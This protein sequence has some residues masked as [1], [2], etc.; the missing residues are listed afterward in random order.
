MS[1]RRLDSVTGAC[2]VGASLH[3]DTCV[4]SIRLGRGDDGTKVR[5]I[6]KCERSSLFL[7]SYSPSLPTCNISLV[8]RYHVC[9]GFKPY[10]CSY[11]IFTREPDPSKTYPF[12]FHGDRCCVRAWRM[13]QA[14]GIAVKDN[15]NRYASIFSS[16]V[17][18]TIKSFPGETCKEIG[19]I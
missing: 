10:S 14:D 17:R 9:V 19:H 5:E 16:R 11:H 3:S 2:T 7:S 15:Y 18:G 13:N 12:F 4:N 6:Q 1:L 8:R